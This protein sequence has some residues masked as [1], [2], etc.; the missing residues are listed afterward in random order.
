MEYKTSVNFRSS[1]DGKNGSE[2]GE[3]SK[4]LV[5]PRSSKKS[6][7]DGRSPSRV[8]NPV[9]IVHKGSTN[10]QTA[11]TLAEYKKPR[12]L[13]SLKSFMKEHGISQKMAPD[14]RER[15]KLVHKSKRRLA[16]KGKEARKSVM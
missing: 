10:S 6:M 4:S 15:G 8:Y 11:S 12:K 13:Q 16:Q 3:G 7:V 14:V 2:L 1:P 9:I 5:A